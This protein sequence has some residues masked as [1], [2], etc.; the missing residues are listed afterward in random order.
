[1]RK[2][3]RTG[4]VAAA[5]SC[6]MLT[7]VVLA[8]CNNK[9]PELTMDEA[10]VT[11]GNYKEI[12]ISVDQLTVTDED[13]QIYAESAV[14]YYN[15]YA[16][17][18]RTIIEEGDK[19]AVTLYLCTESGEMIEGANDSPDIYVTA[20]SGVPYEEVD[21]ALIGA[22]VNTAIEVPLTLSSGEPGIGY[23][24]IG[25]ILEDTIELDSM[26]DEQAASL[27][28]SLAMDGD[29][30]VEGFYAS[31]R[32]LLEQQNEGTMNTDTYNAIYDYL[33]ESCTVDVFPDK[34]LA[35]RLDEHMEQ[36][37]AMCSS[38]YGMSLADYCETIGT[39]E[40]EYKEGIKESLIRD[41]NLELILSAIGEAEG[42]AFDDEAY[43]S[44]LENVMET[45]DYE[46]EAA[47]YEDYGED[48]VR[49]VFQ[50]NCV[51]DWIIDNADITYTAVEGE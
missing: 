47:V 19:V 25:Y 20:G 32:K 22:E 45:R 13:V 6:M 2:Q 10:K 51:T 39:T 24:T 27:M 34:E 33:L 15:T 1:M 29:A 49:R 11:L 23:V 21:K 38:Y 50:A 17:S 5:C 9:G 35:D 37:K 12:E 43:Q 3:M 4:L 26:T 30:S 18:E 7:T 46:S 36:V 42:I 16:E 31:V 41:I 44:Y 40:K 14:N 8:G 28:N 48:Y